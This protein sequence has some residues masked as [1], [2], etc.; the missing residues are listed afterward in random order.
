MSKSLE[1][2]L[3]ELAASADSV[4]LS[5]I[6]VSR[7]REQGIEIP[8]QRQLTPN[9]AADVLF[10]DQ[11]KA[12]AVRMLEQLPE[13]PDVPVSSIQSLY[14]EIRAAI[15]LGLYGAAITLCGILVEYTLKYA[16]YKIEMGGFANYDAEKWD[17][18]ERLDFSA[19]IARANKNRLLTRDARKSL[20][21]FRAQ[22]RNPYNHYNI[23][24]ITSNYLQQPL[25]TLNTRENKVKAQDVAAKDNPIVQA[26]AKP[27][28]DADNVLP[29][30]AFADSVVKYLWIK[31]KDLP[32]LPK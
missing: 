19:A 2:R 29:V 22:F 7:L 21:E 13:R 26:A 4:F 15:A 1:E 8:Q 16:A 20:N 17:E 31:I 32:T 23:R 5:P 6:T 10:A 12:Q 30:Y 14:S 28:A 9:E 27:I 3:R 18:F 25:T 11:R 24:K